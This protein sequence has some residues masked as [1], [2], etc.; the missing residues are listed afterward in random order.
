MKRKI[1]ATATL[2]SV[3]LLIPAAA[4]ATCEPGKIGKEDGKLV[5]RL[6][7]CEPPPQ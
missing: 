2:A 1:I 4:D 7:R 3:L 5:I 6:P